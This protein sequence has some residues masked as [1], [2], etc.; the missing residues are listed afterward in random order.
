[1]ASTQPGSRISVCGSL[2]L[3]Q[4]NV[5][6]VI[7]LLLPRETAALDQP[8]NFF[9]LVDLLTN[10]N[11]FPKP[12]ST[13][14]PEAIHQAAIDAAQSNGFFLEPDSLPAFHLALALHSASPKLEAFYQY[15]KDLTLDGIPLPGGSFAEECGS[16]VD[17]YGQRICTRQELAAV[18]TREAL[19][20]TMDKYEQV[21]LLHCVVPLTFGRLPPLQP[22][23]LLPFDHILPNPST[24]IDTPS[25]TAVLYADVSSPNFRELHAELLLLSASFPPKLTYVFRYVPPNHD[26][27]STREYLSGYGVGLDLKKTDYLVMDDRLAKRRG[28]TKLNAIYRLY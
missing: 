13:L 23:K 10:P 4:G 22:V 5:A 8:S 11:I 14:P 24:N 3:L 15:Y 7:F 20:S 6:N 28:A 9:P 18:A 26:G 25:H 21:P 16:W 27:P 2:Y 17:W 1:M 12:L 19:D